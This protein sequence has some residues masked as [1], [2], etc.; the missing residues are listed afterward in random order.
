MFRE[1]KN[2]NSM[3]EERETETGERDYSKRTFRGKHKV[4]NI[5]E[6]RKP[7]QLKIVTFPSGRQK[8][9]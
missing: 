3:K 4:K 1:S 7:N 8:P 9:L 5:T 6:T 2:E